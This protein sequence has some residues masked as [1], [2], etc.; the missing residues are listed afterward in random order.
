MI[1]PRIAIL[2][3]PTFALEVI[4]SVV[5]VGHFS[6][7]EERAF[8]CG[9][10]ANQAGGG[11]CAGGGAVRLVTKLHPIGYGGKP[12]ETEP[13]G[14]W[15]TT[16]GSG[17]VRVRVLRRPSGRTRRR[18]RRAPRQRYTVTKVERRSPSLP[19]S[20]STSACGFSFAGFWLS[21]GQTEE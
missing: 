16:T 5:K 2:T 11:T 15:R 14:R 10:W 17:Q 7:R 19:F 9:K 6:R 4:S 21:A 1:L 3:K 20:S 18:R 13:S 8:V 12:W